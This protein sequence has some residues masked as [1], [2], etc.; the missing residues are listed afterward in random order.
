MT[1]PPPRTD[2]K[3]PDSADVARVVSVARSARSARAARAGTHPTVV[4]IDGPAGSGK[5][6]LATLVSERLGASLVH[7]D[8]LFPGWD[9]LAAAP[10]LLAAQVLT[11]IHR[12]EPASYRRFDWEQYA[13]A[14]AVPVDAGAYLLVEG[15]GSS[16]GPARPLTEVRVWLEAPWEERRRRGIDRDGDMFAPHW[17]RWARQEQELYAADDTAAHAH[18]RLVTG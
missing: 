3:S 10:A 2:H 11:P 4:A 15:C 12:G 18:L 17:E 7:M 5:T 9:G 6:S 13:F 16:V 14:E 8:D 1:V